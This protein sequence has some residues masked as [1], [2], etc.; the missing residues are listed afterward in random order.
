M[1]LSMVLKTTMNRIILEWTYLISFIK[2]MIPQVA[3]HWTGSFFFES[4]V[5]PLTNGVYQVYESSMGSRVHFWF[6]DLQKW[7]MMGYE[8]I[9]E[10]I[11]MGMKRW[12]VSATVFVDQ[13]VPIILSRL[14]K[15][16][17]WIHDH[18]IVLVKVM[19]TYRV[20]ME[21]ME[22][23]TFI[24]GHWICGLIW[25]WYLVYID[26]LVSRFGFF[27]HVVYGRMKEVDWDLVVRKGKE[28]IQSIISKLKI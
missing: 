10:L 12:H 4:I 27:V 24:R 22:I 20:E 7:G 8:S 28:A 16:I 19:E 6:M 11:D 1:F 17:G 13:H 2:V 21:S 23:V 14:P 18:V 25:E 9:V 5:R 26:P 3:D 15:V